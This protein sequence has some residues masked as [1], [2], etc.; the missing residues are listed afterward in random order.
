MLRIFLIS[1]CAVWCCAAETEEKEPCIE[2][3]E[4]GKYFSSQNFPDNFNKDYDG[5]QGVNCTFQLK[6]EEG[7]KVLLTFYSID[8]S[9]Y[10][11]DS[12]LRILNFNETDENE[13]DNSY[14]CG[15]SFNNKKVLSETNELEFQFYHQRWSSYKGWLAK[16]EAVDSQMDINQQDKYLV[17]YPGNFVKNRTEQICVESLDGQQYDV[18][19]HLIGKN[20]DEPFGFR[21]PPL[22]PVP[23]PVPFSSRAA[24]SEE[25]GAEYFEPEENDIPESTETI[26]G[27][28]E[29]CLEIKT[30][31]KATRAMLRILISGD[32]GFNEELYRF[33]NVHTPKDE[34]LIQTDKGKYKAGSNVTFR[35]ITLDDELKSSGLKVSE[36]KVTDPKQRIIK[37]WKLPQ[38]EDGINQQSFALFEEAPL[39]RYTIT[40]KVD[41]AREVEATFEVAEYT[42]PR[43]E[44]SLK[45]PSAVVPGSD[46]TWKV[47]ADYTHGAPVPGSIKASFSIRRNRWED[48]QRDYFNKTVDKTS[49][50]S[51]C[52]DVV[53]SSE[54]LKDLTKSYS[55]STINLDIEFTED[56][57]EEIQTASSRNTLAK[58]EF[59]IEFGSSTNNF[60]V[61][62][63]P[64][65]G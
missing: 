47:C 51:S 15:K 42:L 46:S 9:S 32:N 38:N 16:Y 1:V 11:D 36:I 2:T 58:Q 8:L 20:F 40:V 10:C 29:E 56:G 49:E 25:S 7:K 3:P 4:V 64:Y 44:I 60:V 24:L 22:P 26:E 39:G 61:G 6:V 41:D 33:V 65:T 13:R 45:D 63:F 34:V 62:G 5:R 21:R 17:H 19:V 55:K 31:M 14:L 57:T 18:T 48:G 53:L 27:T 50:E 37:Q 52:T 43:F 23:R 54:E 35:W 28:S 30:T 12:Y 59:Q